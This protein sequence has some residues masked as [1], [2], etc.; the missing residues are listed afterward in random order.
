MDPIEELPLPYVEIDARGVVT[1]ANRASHELYPAECGQLVGLM[2]W[3][4]VAPDEKDLS[5]AAYCTS[6]ETGKVAA[7]VRRSLFDRSGQFR[8]YEMYRSLVRDA[9]GNPAGMRMVC[10]DVSAAEKEM[11][12]VRSKSSWL[13]SVM[14]SIS[15]AILVTD[16]VGFIR[17]A[18]PA[19]EALLGWKAAE[20]SGM[21]IEEGLPIES[22]LSSDRTE[23]PFTRSLEGA[24]KGVA[25]V[26]DRNRCEMKI[27]IKTSPIFDKE[28]GSTAGV[29]LLL[30]RL[31]NS[32]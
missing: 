5:F 22:Y 28:T 16:A 15:E 19:A 24:T 6:I 13:E 27:E 29:V 25:T 30:H 7:M 8:T 31:E 10:V 17:S 23:L 9:E 3:K 14:D 1:R 12:E 11:A 20:L 18:N 4:L 32:V 26:L 21:P 2:A